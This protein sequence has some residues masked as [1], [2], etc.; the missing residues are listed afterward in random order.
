MK[1]VKLAAIILIILAGIIGSYLILKNSGQANSSVN[2]DKISELSKA[3]LSKNPIQWVEKAKE[4]ISATVN[5]NS[6]N[7]SAA[8]SSQSVNLTNMVAGSMFGGMQK[9]DQSG[10]NPF[11]DFDPDDPESQKLIQETIAGLQNP[12]ANFSQSVDDKDLKIS[13]DN[14]KEAVIKYLTAI[15]EIAQDRMAGFNKSYQDV[16][17]EI[18][19]INDFSLALRFADIQKNIANDYL[20]LI[21][22]SDWVDVHKKLIIHFKTSEVVFKALSDYANDP[23]KSYLALQMIDQLAVNAKENQNSL[24]QKIKEFGL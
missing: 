2:N 21:V 24:Q 7:L 6:E 4:Q 16:L 18:S 1:H 12:S 8:T 20:D 11:E 9:L 22:P 14:S 3:I 15:N 23:V 5:S 19:K 10:T 17:S 13:Q